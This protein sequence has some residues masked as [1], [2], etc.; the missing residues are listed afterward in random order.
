MIVNEGGKPHRSPGVHKDVDGVV[1]DD[2]E[3]GKVENKHHVQGHQEGLP[4]LKKHGYR[5]LLM[6]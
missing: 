1:E 3:S 5:H 6:V 2:I 4:V